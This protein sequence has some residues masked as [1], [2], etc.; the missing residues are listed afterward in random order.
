MSSTGT[1]STSASVSP[2]GNSRDQ[3]L[4]PTGSRKI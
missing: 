3:E 2:K 1:K 4:K